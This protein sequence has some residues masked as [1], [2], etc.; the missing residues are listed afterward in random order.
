MVVLQQKLKRLKVVLRR[1]NQIHYAEISVKVGDKRKELEVI[2]MEILNGCLR[3]SLIEKEKEITNELREL[4]LVE[5][6]FY[7]QKSRIQWIQEG[8]QNTSFFHGMVAAKQ[9]KN[10]IKGL[11]DAEGNRLTSPTQISEEA[12]GYFEKLI[13]TVDENVEGCLEEILEE[14]FPRLPEE[15]STELIR[16]ITSEEIKQ[17]MFSIDGEKAPGPDGFTSHFFKIAWTIVGREVVNAVQHF[18]HTSKL[19]PVFNST[20]ITL[21][22]K[23]Q[24]PNSIKDFRPISCCNVI[25]KCVTKI[26]VNRMKKYLPAIIGRNQ[27]AFIP[28]RSIT[29]NI[30]MAQ[31]LVRGYGRTILSLR[32]AIKVDLQKAFDTV[33]WKF[34]IGVLNVL[35]FPGLFVDWIRSCLTGSRFSISIN[36]GLVRYFQGTRGYDRE[37]QCPHTCLCF[38][39]MCYQ[40]FLMLQWCIGCLITTQNA[41]G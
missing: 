32:C 19:L 39:L 35:K 9:N 33:S 27:S 17:S 5:E 25:Y 30:L 22:P 11:T 16:P 26:L 20:I 10:T 38:Q 6:S 24:N 12:V 15:A 3:T 40:N 18:F 37:I 7:Q 2:Q 21:V 28:S 8:D 14:L 41:K 31:E 36:G 34:I 23:C 1:F 29:D 4:R 13:G